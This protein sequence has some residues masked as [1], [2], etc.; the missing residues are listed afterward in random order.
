V[1]SLNGSLGFEGQV[2]VRV[3][4]HLDLNCLATFIFSLE[5][6][7]ADIIKH[8][9][10]LVVI[11][12]LALQKLASLHL[13]VVTPAKI[14]HIQRF[15][16]VSDFLIGIKITDDPEGEDFVKDFV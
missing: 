2:E 10:C 13:F 14:I 12:V 9:E 11:V 7:E 8:L 1:S 15:P 5:L 6:F 4:C 16:V 3:V